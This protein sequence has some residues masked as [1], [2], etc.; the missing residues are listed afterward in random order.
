[1]NDILSGLAGGGAMPENMIAPAYMG[2]WGALVNNKDPYAILADASL[3]INQDGEFS[4]SFVSDL[5]TDIYN[6]QG[7]DVLT[8]IKA[9]QSD[10]GGSPYALVTAYVPDGEIAEINNRIDDLDKAVRDYTPE[11]LLSQA[12]YKAL[13]LYEELNGEAEV[14][15]AV[16]AYKVRREERLNEQKQRTLVEYE[17][18]R[19]LRGMQAGLELNRLEI[20]SA[21][22]IS[23]YEAK[24]RLATEREDV[25]LKTQLVGQAV[26]IAATHLQSRHNLVTAQF[27]TSKMSIVAKQDQYDKDLEYE[28]RDALWDLELTPYMINALGSLSGSVIQS[29]GQTQ[30]ERLLAMITQSAQIG[31]Q[32]GSAAGHPAAG[33]GAGAGMF[34][35]RALLGV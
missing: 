28:T 20:E 16:D 14:S 7:I 4:W 10:V 2:Q 24:L 34:A 22:D 8:A 32:A 15:D 26:Q 13:E 19:A 35:L 23:E 9:A 12:V 31:I 3:S 30:G 33:V 29:R 25:G 5:W 1:M 21:R 27:D 18:A 17:N 6:D 11:I